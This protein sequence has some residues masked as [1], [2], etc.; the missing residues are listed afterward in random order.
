MHRTFVKFF[1]LLVF[2]GGVCYNVMCYKYHI[3]VINRIEDYKKKELKSCYTPVD[4]PFC[5]TL[6]RYLLVTIN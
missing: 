1:I 2:S 3:Y 6:Y 4:V 5:G